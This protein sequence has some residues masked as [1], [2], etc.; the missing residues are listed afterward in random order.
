MLSDFLQP[1]APAFG[2]NPFAGS[3][4]LSVP[5]SVC[6]G[7]GLKRNIKCRLGFVLNVKVSISCSDCCVQ[8]KAKS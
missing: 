8:M 5:R 4:F 3:D 7:G 2:F 1:P 6:G